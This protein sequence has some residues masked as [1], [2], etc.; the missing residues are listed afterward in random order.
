MIF[1][2][3]KVLFHLRNFVHFAVFEASASLVFQSLSRP[4]WRLMGYELKGR[5]NRS[6][7]GGHFLTLSGESEGPLA[8]T[9]SNSQTHHQ[10]TPSQ[11]GRSAKEPVLLGLLFFDPYLSI[12]C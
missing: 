9:G 12:F 4:R 6:R 11:S 8:H 1:P 3:R 7:I 10:R 2:R 5:P